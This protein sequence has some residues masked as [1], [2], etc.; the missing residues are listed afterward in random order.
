MGEGVIRPNPTLKGGGM[1]S[2]PYNISRKW[3]RT[4]LIIQRVLG[5][6]QEK[7]VMGVSSFDANCA[8]S[9]G[10]RLVPTRGKMTSPSLSDT[11]EAFPTSVAC[12]LNNQTGLWPNGTLRNG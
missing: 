6:D 5:A 10:R 7:S 2:L 4:D 8:F 12:E 9:M 3:E 11:C 1:Q